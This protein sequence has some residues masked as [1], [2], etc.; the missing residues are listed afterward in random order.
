[1][2]KTL[3][4]IILRV[5]LAQE[6]DKGS[7][8]MCHR[9]VEK[10]NASQSK[11]AGN[12]N[13]HASNS[14]SYYPAPLALILE[15]PCWDG[16]DCIHQSDGAF[17][18]KVVG[19]RKTV[20]EARS[21]PLTQ[22]SNARLIA[23]HH[24]KVAEVPEELNGT[25]ESEELIFLGDKPAASTRQTL[26]FGPSSIPN[27]SNSGTSDGRADGKGSKGTRARS[28]D[29]GNEHHLA[30]NEDIFIAN[31][32][33]Q[34]EPLL[35]QKEAPKANFTDNIYTEHLDDVDTTAEASDASLA[36]HYSGNEEA[37]NM[38]RSP[39]IG[40]VDLLEQIIEDA[41]NNKVTTCYIS[42]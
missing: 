8:L 13:N 1:M 14:T 42:S 36:V 26:C 12:A 21:A 37:L 17:V 35:V 7:I 15:A 30:K 38:T 29:G 16:N 34:S 27:I 20:E 11:F 6:E 18:S 19:E 3:F 5:Y 2:W 23:M 33:C 9:T 39:Q 4:S 41:K 28:A 25:A 40:E 22:F 24:L 32:V 10:V 31:L